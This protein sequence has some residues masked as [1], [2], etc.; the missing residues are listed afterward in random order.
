MIFYTE[1]E[2]GPHERFENHNC[3][4]KLS[5][6]LKIRGLPLQTDACFLFSFLSFFSP[7]RYLIAI[8]IWS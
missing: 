3:N 6:L 8:F 4:F 7:C 5:I 2:A 1:T